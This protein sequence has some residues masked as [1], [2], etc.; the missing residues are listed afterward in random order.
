M[1]GGQNNRIFSIF[2]IFFRPILF[3]ASADAGVKS[4]YNIRTSPSISSPRGHRAGD[5][6][7]E[8]LTLSAR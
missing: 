6:A 5:G 4:R 3:P 2:S 1:L 7:S 8:I